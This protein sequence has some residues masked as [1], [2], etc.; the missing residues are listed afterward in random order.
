MYRTNID[1]QKVVIRFTQ[2]QQSFDYHIVDEAIKSI[3]QLQS[4]ILLYKKQCI[5][6]IIDSFGYV[7]SYVQDGEILDI[8]IQNIIPFDNVFNK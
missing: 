4:K 1:G 7:V 2:T 3:L 5:A 6:T 8:Q